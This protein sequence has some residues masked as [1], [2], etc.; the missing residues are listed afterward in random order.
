MK[1]V[2][3]V[4]GARLFLSTAF[5]S[6]VA[7][8]AVMFPSES[9]AQKKPKQGGGQQHIFSGPAPEHPFDIILARPTSTTITIS[10]MSARPIA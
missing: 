2:K 7:A 8:F 1:P 9:L 10:V 5:L 3:S 6:L 4:M